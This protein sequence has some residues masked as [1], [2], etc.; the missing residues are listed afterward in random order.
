MSTSSGPSPPRPAR[1]RR[2][3]IRHLLAR[4]DR[5]VNAFGAD[6]TDA[7]GSVGVGDPHP[8]E[9]RQADA[10][11]TAELQRALADPEPLRGTAQLVSRWAA[12][13]ARIHESAGQP[14]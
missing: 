12:A 13:L 6:W 8:S 1:S 11:A 4:D 3:R 14:A 5:D 2:P 9:P 10:I 7:G